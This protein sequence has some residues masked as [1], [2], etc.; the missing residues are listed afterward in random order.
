MRNL[1]LIALLMLTIPISLSRADDVVTPSELNAHPE[2]YDGKTVTVRGYFL[3]GTEIFAI[4]DSK[5]AAEN[6]D[7]P[8]SQ[9]IGYDYALDLREKL[10]ALNHHVVDVTAKF[11]PS[12][13]FRD[14]KRYVQFGL[15]NKSGVIILDAPKAVGN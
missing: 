13:M 6:P 11:L 5:A 8:P 14:G 15:C 9:C 7:S 3:W 10:K 1:M 12:L 4:F 2:Q